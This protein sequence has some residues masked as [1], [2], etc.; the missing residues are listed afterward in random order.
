MDHKFAVTLDAVAAR[1]G[2]RPS[3]L[4]GLTPQTLVALAF[5]IQVASIGSQ[6]ERDQVERAKQNAIGVPSV[7]EMREFFRS[8]PE[9]SI[10]RRKA[11]EMEALANG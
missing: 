1:Y 3:D 4:V 5:D 10:V 8:L 9:D 2:Q 6:N 7:D 11:E